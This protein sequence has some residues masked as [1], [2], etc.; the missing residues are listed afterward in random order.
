MTFAQAIW[1]LSRM[2]LKTALV[3]IAPDHRLAPEHRLASA[4]DDACLT[5][6]WLKGQAM[7]EFRYKAG[8]M[9]LAPVRVRG[10]VLVAPFFCGSVRTKS[11]QEHPC[12]AFWNLEMYDRLGS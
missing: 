10:Y 11:E 8:S 12:E 6:K 9:E 4:F 1:A 3:I 2:S 5:L 7:H